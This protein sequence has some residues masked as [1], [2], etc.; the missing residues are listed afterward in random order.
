MEEAELDEKAIFNP[1]KS[2][3]EGS[4]LSSDE[5]FTPHHSM[6]LTEQF[7][8]IIEFQDSKSEIFS[9]KSFR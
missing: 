5:Y 7:I 2:D 4:N 6:R 8:A 9:D 1:M 3:N